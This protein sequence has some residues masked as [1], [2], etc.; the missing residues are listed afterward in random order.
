MFVLV[1]D[2]GGLGQGG[3]HGNTARK[4]TNFRK[5]WHCLFCAL[6]YPRLPEQ[7]LEHNMCFKNIS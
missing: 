5:A 2:G 1:S 3:G 7:C 4:T 6:M